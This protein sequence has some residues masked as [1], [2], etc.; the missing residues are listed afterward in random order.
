MDVLNSK[1]FIYRMQISFLDFSFRVSYVQRMFPHLQGRVVSG[2][3]NNFG[4]VL[5]STITNDSLY[6][7]HLI[8][9][10]K[11]H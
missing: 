3:A 1:Y 10:Q 11:N 2:H 7:S 6:G 4:I 5:H 8:R 9:D